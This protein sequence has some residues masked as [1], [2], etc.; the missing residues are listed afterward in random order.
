MKLSILICAYNE[1]KS[2]GPL[3]KN[4]RRQRAPPEIT[5]SEIIVVTSGC[6][7]GTVKAVRDQM[8]EDESI[9]LIEEPTRLGKASA[10][11]KAFEA[12]TGDYIAMVPADVEPANDALFNL[13]VPFRSRGVAA[14]SG[15]P[16]QNFRNPPKNT[17]SY[18]AKKTYRLWRRLMRKLNDEGR[19]AHCSGEFMAVRSDVNPIVPNDCAA[20]DSYI[21]IMAKKKGLVKFAPDALCYNILPSNIADYVNQRKRWLYGHFQTKKVT[22]EYP[23]VMDTVVLSKPRMACQILKEE[24]RES[25][26]EVGYLLAAIIVEA[27]IYFLCMIDRLLSRETG[28]WPIIRSTKHV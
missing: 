10:L 23:T 6:T 18:L 9:L 1:E 28:V 15:N 16:Q 13:L 14:V 4:L 26:E 27:V 17:V 19:M 3:L 12:S 7:D 25:P 22:G 11:N 20:D 2:I 21:A 24:I 5:D 8:R